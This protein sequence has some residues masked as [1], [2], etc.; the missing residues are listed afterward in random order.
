MGEII[1]K[2]PGNIKEVF[3]V[4]LPLPSEEILNKIKE[5]VNE[6]EKKLKILKELTEKYQGKLDIPEVNE[7]ELYE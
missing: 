6:K 1:I 7:D 3:E 4:N 2:V 5:L